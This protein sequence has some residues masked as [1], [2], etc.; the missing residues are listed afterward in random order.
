MKKVT[1][2]AVVVLCVQMGGVARAAEP[3]WTI[4]LVGGPGPD[5]FKVALSADGR[6]YQIDSVA[7]LEVGGTVCKHPGG[8]PLQLLCDA[9]SVAGFEV[10]GEGDADVVEIDAKVSVPVT[11]S[12]GIGDDKLIGGGS[13]DKLIGGDGFDHLIGGGGNDEIAGGAGGDTVTG[14]LGDDRLAGEGGQDTLVGGDG[15]DS[16]LGGPKNDKLLGGAGNDRISGGEGRDSLF[17][18]TGDDRFFNA[19]ADTVVGGPGRD[20]A[21]PGGPVK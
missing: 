20:V 21:V 17:G 15:N 18:G 13:G 7:P 2:I 8:D 3:T 19:L 5:S 6:T 9:P 10:N 14:D 11:L 12:G 4:L 16:L 1:L